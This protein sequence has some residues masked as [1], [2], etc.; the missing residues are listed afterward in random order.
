MI[1]PLL[2]VYSI[3]LIFVHVHLTNFLIHISL[4]PFLNVQS[5]LIQFDDIIQQ[6]QLI[7]DQLIFLIQLIVHS[8]NYILLN[9]LMK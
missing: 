4:D 9:L 7:I 1:K 8:L 3:Q 5:L 6:D 2:M